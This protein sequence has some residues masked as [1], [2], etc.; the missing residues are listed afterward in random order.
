MGV[1]VC[2]VS[3]AALLK[4]KGLACLKSYQADVAEQPKGSGFA[5]LLLPTAVEEDYSTLV[6][7]LITA[8]KVNCTRNF[9]K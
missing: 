3:E 1:G 8:L 6:A 5:L 7:Q 2:I 4:E 9:G